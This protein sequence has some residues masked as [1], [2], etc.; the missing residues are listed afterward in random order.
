MIEQK[1]NYFK[2]TIDEITIKNK[3]IF[4]YIITNKL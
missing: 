4:K 2:P 3:N 1:M